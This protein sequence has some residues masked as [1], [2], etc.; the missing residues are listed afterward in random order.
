MSEAE[1]IAIAGDVLDAM[2]AHA[3]REAPNECCGLL[4][5]SPGRIDESIAATN[6]AASASRF[7]LDPSEHIA[8]N[9]RL[10]G[11]TREVVGTYH[12]HPR[13]PAV[14]SPTDVAEAYYSEF[15]HVIVSLMDAARADVRAYRILGLQATPVILRVDSR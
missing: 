2:I 9:R 10:R 15:V 5:G 8:I 1:S 6:L 12:S 11:S 14:P 13:S 4:V 7:L 3:R